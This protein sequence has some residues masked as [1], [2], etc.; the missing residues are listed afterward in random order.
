MKKIFIPF[1]VFIAAITSCNKELDLTPTD[2]IDFTKAFTSVEDLEKG[3]LGVYAANSHINKIYIA[4]ILSD[5][6]KISNENRGQGQFTFKWQ[7]SGA[8]AEH[9]ADYAQYYV[10]L[11]RLHRV[12]AAID[13]VPANGQLESNRK[14]RV[15]AELIGLRGIALYELLVRFMP[16]GYDPSA[17][18][19]AIMLKSDITAAP[20]RNTV[21]EVVAQIETDLAEAR[22]DVNIANAPS[23]VLRLSKSG[24]AA[25]QARLSLL[26][27]DWATAITFATD[28]IN[29]SGKS[30]ATGNTYVSY[31]ADVNES[32]SI[33]KFRNQSA[34]QLLWRDANGDVFFEP[35]DKLKKQFDRI[36][37]IRYSTF[38]GS[39]G[40]DTSIVKKYPGSSFG[41]QINDQKLIRISEMYLIRAEAYA[42][43]NQLMLAAA[44]LNAVRAA[45]ISGYVPV[46]FAS[47]DEAVAAIINERFKELCFEGFRF[48][49]LKRKSL[50]INRDASDVQSVNW[51][52]LSAN[53]F[54]FALPLPSDELDANPNA[55]QNPGY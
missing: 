4:S 11:D 42:E 53:D 13:Q 43:S 3:L 49:D 20:S 38:F 50:G 25:Y 10:M 21:G 29:L 7:Y 33:F 55:V 40:G 12:L 6:T 36:N 15:R 16:S 39:A 18:G 41:P 34:P 27:R 14:A 47:K 17:S 45:R 26:K 46:S 19:V 23:E 28:A 37:D 5:E 30:L 54:H 51:Q 44:D 8:E 9:N 31:W 32:E 1:L 35:S 24:I 48:F 2:N 52:N 22:A